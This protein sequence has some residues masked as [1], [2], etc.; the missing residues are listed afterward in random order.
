MDATKKITRNLGGDRLGSGSKNNIELHKYHRSTHDLSRAWRSSMNVGT[1]VPFLVEPAL[2]GDTWSINLSAIARTIPAVGPLYGSFKLQLD[3]FLCPIRLYNGLLH[4]NMT[5]IGLHMEQVKLPKLVLTT[6]WQN[7]NKISEPINGLQISPSSLLSYLGINGIGDSNSSGGATLVRKFNAIPI[8]AYYDIYKNYYANKQEEKG[9][10]IKPEITEQEGLI[11][12]LG[13]EYKLS[14]YIGPVNY[15]V[16]YMGFQNDDGATPAPIPITGQH[17]TGSYAPYVPVVYVTNDQSLRYYIDTLGNIQVDGSGIEIILENPTSPGSYIVEDID[18]L[19]PNWNNPGTGQISLNA[20]NPLSPYDGWYIVGIGYD[21]QKTY[22]GKTHLEVF[23]LENIDDMKIEIF[24]NT[25]LGVE[26]LINQIGKE[27]YKALSDVDPD[28]VTYNKHKQNGLAIKTYQSDLLNNWLKTEW[29]DG[30][31]GINEITAIDTSSGSF[32]IDALN[33]AHKIYN[34]LNRIAVSGGSSYDYYEAVYSVE[35]TRQMETPI[36]CGGMST[37]I[38]FEEVI[39]TAQSGEQ[40]LGTLAGKGTV[41]NT[42]GGHIE[43]K[44]ADEPCFIIGIVSITPRLD[45]SQGNKWYMTELDSVADLH[46]PA[47]D[48]IGFEDLLQERAAWWGTYWDVND[49]EWKKL[50]MGKVP[51]WISYMTALN[52]T[53]GDFATDGTNDFMVL[54]RGYEYKY[55]NQQKLEGIKDATTYIDPTKFQ[56]SFADNS[57]DAQNFWVQIGMEIYARRVMSAKVI[58]YL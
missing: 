26:Y 20:G 14:H 48:G 17:Y 16:D 34:M 19:F 45:Y 53:H 43:I 11:I 54:N 21:N 32:Q 7:P 35:V 13:K 51:A 4:S 25:G 40:P 10:I 58:P 31:G 18:T 36:Y 47:L 2:P 52:E 23:D 30:S 12:G 5:K 37:E 3:T 39:S 28:G 56:Y 38:V 6:E 9:V 27:P 41:T 50:A 15:G 57:L 33:L 29:I 8:L 42:K 24:Q 44:V 55:N 1:L 49:Q 46:K 22:T